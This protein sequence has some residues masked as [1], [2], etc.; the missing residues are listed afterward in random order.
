MLSKNSLEQRQSIK[1][2]K[3]DSTLARNLSLNWQV[4]RVIE[5]KE[6]KEH[7]K[8]YPQNLIQITAQIYKHQNLFSIQSLF[9]HN[10]NKFML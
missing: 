3:K 7:K 1:N 8:L 2:Y 10:Q 5:H 4:L 9:K 6:L